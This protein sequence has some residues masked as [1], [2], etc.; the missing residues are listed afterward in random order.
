MAVPTGT[1]CNACSPDRG[2][3]PGTAAGFTLL[4]VVVTISV[5]VLVASMSL[6]TISHMLTAGADAQAHNILAAQLVS[7]RASAITKNNYFGI[8]AQMGASDV[9]ERMKF[10]RGKS[11]VSIVELGKGIVGY[12]GTTGAYDPT[13]VTY[14]KGQFGLAEG[15]QP[16]KL[17]GNMAVGEISADFV[18]SEGD[19]KNLDNSGLA[20]FCSLTII[21]NPDGAICKTANG[22]PLRFGLYENSLTSGLPPI[23]IFKLAHP[24]DLGYLWDYQ[25]LENGVENPVAAFTLFDYSEVRLRTSAQ[26]VTYL[27]E[28]GLLMAI[29]V[30]TGQLLE[31]K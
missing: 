20:D 28:Y 16:R 27:N 9:A 17:P 18:T 13:Y 10:N 7:A 25:K 1:A 26:R 19:Y 29:N 21:F 8:H 30:H 12:T 14:D 23:N 5:I 11:F 2:N 31:R 15:H 3:L 4:E 22:L 6:P 24:Y